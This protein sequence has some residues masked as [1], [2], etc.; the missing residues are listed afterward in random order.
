MAIKFP[1][2]FMKKKSLLFIPTAISDIDKPMTG[3]RDLQAERLC[4]RRSQELGFCRKTGGALQ[5]GCWFW[6]RKW[7]CETEGP[8]GGL[9][10]WACNPPKVPD[11][12][13]AWC[14]SWALQRAERCPRPSPT[15]AR[16]SPEGPFLS[17]DVT[18][19]LRDRLTVD[20]GRKT[21]MPC[22]HT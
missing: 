1:F 15:H 6:G 19:F 18:Q 13:N 20:P 10:I 4:R 22:T 11:Q 14:A 7:P 17:S 8:D 12:I 9:G 3:L 2:Y 16:S 21:L 5:G